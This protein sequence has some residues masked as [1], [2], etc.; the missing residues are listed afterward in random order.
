MSKK[1]T[2]KDLSF[3]RANELLNYDP[4]T[5]YLTWN[6]DIGNRKEGDR[7]GKRRKKKSNNGAQVTIDK[8]QYLAH[9]VIWLLYYGFFPENG[10]AHKD[11]DLFNCKIK[12]GI[13]VF[14]KLTSGFNIR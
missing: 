13:T 1:L 10:I 14:S 7:T 11:N 9:R 6:Q 12:F 2:T 5:G 3:E 4:D 8:K